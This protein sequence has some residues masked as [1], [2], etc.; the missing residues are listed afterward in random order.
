MRQEALKFIVVGAIGFG[1]DS[2]I[3]QLIVATTETSPLIARAISFPIAVTVTWFLNR[4]WT[5]KTGREQAEGKQYIRYVA[6]QIAGFTINYAI[7]AILILQ[8]G[9]WRTW[10]IIA[11]AAGS[12][13]AMFVT[14]FASQRIVFAAPAENR[15]NT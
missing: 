11:L 8:G 14:F 7:F 12:V 5:F 10:P 3:M 13:L 4:V 9:I 6:V 15:R 1:V 2:G